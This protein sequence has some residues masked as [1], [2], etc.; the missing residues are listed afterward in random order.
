[1]ASRGLA[2]AAL[3]S[4]ILCA[5]A[6]PGAANPVQRTFSWTGFYA[7]LDAGY[8]WDAGSISR[9]PTVQLNYPVAFANNGIPAS[10]DVS[11]NGVLGGIHGGYNLQANRIIFGIETDIAYSG[12]RG[13]NTSAGR[14]G[15]GPGAVTITTTENKKLAWFGTLRGRIGALATPSVL[16][17]ATG[18]LAYGEVSSSTTTSVPEAVFTGGCSGA[19]AGNFFCSS[20][21]FAGWR[22]GWT[23]GAGVET[24][25]GDRWSARAEYLYYDLGQVSYMNHSTIVLPGTAVMQ[26]DT[27]FDGHIVRLGLSYKFN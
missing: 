23:I 16:A 21:S 26:T 22:A 18:G 1:M 2:L 9:N 6:C 11:A 19:F 8:G 14:S 24:S 27:R 12:L 17:Y 4:A 15:T 20:G 5:Q 13:S 25:L 3:A 10:S 7:G